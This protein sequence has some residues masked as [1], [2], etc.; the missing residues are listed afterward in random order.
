MKVLAV[1]LTFG[2]IEKPL[3]TNIS[4]QPLF[5]SKSLAGSLTHHIA[6]NRSAHL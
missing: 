1:V 6:P 2:K 4:V 5:P 3:D